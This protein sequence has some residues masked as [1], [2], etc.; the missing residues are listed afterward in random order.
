MALL[1]LGNDLN[2]V[3]QRNH[4]CGLIDDFP[5][6][7]RIRLCLLMLDLRGLYRIEKKEGTSFNIHACI[8]VGKECMNTHAC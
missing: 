3:N 5:T 1:T 4:G 6:L 2:F 8:T 7:E